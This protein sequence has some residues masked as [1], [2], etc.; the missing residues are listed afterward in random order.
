MI[1]LLFIYIVLLL[2]TFSQYRSLSIFNSSLT[3]YE[4]EKLRVINTNREKTIAV[5]IPPGVYNQTENLNDI[6]AC[7][8]TLFY[9]D[10]AHSTRCFPHL[11]YYLVFSPL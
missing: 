8:A 4:I 3:E 10:Y 1:F 9:P 5:H 11:Y 2:A 7:N 6:V